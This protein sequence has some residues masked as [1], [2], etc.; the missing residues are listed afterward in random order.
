[1]RPNLDMVSSRVASLRQAHE[2]LAEAVCVVASAVRDARPDAASRFA[3]LVQAAELE[4][5]IEE[6]SFFPFLDAAG[7][8]TTRL[9]RDHQQLTQMLARAGDHL[10]RGAIAEFCDLAHELV[11]AFSAHRIREERSFRACADHEV[12]PAALP[13]ADRA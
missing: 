7:S 2:R 9:R 12:A 1:M 3:E 8:D 6:Q 10:R 5:S 11:I 13:G 4:M